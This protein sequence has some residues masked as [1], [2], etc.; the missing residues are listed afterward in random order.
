MLRRVATHTFSTLLYSP[1][2]LGGYVMGDILILSKHCSH[3]F[4]KVRLVEAQRTALQI[5]PALTG[6]LFVPRNAFWNGY[7]N[8]MTV[9][10]AERV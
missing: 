3:I 8:T 5:R 10:F 1:I 7:K 4:H 2:C 6:M 9:Q